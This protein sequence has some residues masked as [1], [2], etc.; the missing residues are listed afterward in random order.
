V[1]VKRKIFLGMTPCSVMEIYQCVRGTTCFFVVSSRENHVGELWVRYREDV[2][3]K[4]E[5]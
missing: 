4:C 3:Y 5:S 2:H 1:V